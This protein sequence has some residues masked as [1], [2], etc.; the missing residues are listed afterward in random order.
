M[1]YKNP[2]YHKEYR[3]N[4]KE[5]IKEKQKEYCSRHEVKK[6]KKEYYQENKEHLRLKQKEYNRTPEQRIKREL[7][8][9]RRFKVDK[10]FHI[11]HKLGVSLRDAF[12]HYSTTGKIKSSCSYGIN[13]KAIIKHLKPFPVDI[14]NYHIDHIIPLS[15]F[16]FN[17][18]EHIKIAFAPENHQW[19]IIKEN[20]EKGDK[21]IMPH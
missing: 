13:Y 15:R 3:E 7:R 6:H 20:L 14:E 5:K 18:P 2:N 1:T 21:L 17:N 19:L 10:H 12:N 16:D 11:R 9:K 4:N 8:R